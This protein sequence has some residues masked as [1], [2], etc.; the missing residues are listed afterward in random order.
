[1]NI[2]DVMFEMELGG[3]DSADIAVIIK[4]YEGKVLNSDIIDNELLKRGYPKIFTI[5]YDAYDEYNDW[6]DDYSSIEKFPHKPQ[7]GD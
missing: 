5:D 7:Y 6:D 4:L 2:S 1:M 3:V